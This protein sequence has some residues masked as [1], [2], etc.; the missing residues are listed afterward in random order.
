MTRRVERYHALAVRKLD[1]FSLIELL[2]VIAVIAVLAALLV[3]A[4]R[5]AKTQAHAIQCLSQLKQFSY[6]WNLYADDHDE[7]IPPN[8]P[9][10]AEPV[11][12][13]VGTWVWGLLDPG[14]N[15]PD[16]T[17]TVYLTE[18]LLAPYLA[19]S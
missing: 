7:R 8:I 11:I 13:E 18:S 14:E 5:A 17:N 15:W 2:V 10:G 9:I 6:A 12:S 3:P 1:S 4:L 16:N 19:R